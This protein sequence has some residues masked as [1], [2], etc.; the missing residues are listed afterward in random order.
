MAYVLADSP[1]Q[2]SS[3]SGAVSA[4]STRGPSATATKPAAIA[5]ASSLAD[6]PPSGPLSG[7]EAVAIYRAGCLTRALDRQ[8]RVMQRAGQGFWQMLPTG[9]IGA[10]DHRQRPA[11]LTRQP[12]GAA[13][14]R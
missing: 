8:S 13:R 5:L 9:P 7:T 11:R 1:S 2:D 12:F 14:G 3:A 4:R 6:S 10:G